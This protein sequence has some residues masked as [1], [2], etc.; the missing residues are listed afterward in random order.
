MPVDLS[1]A[2]LSDKSAEKLHY[3]G[4]DPG[5]H[6]AFTVDT[7]VLIDTRYFGVEMI[8]WLQSPCYWAKGAGNF[9]GETTEEDW[10][11]VASPPQSPKQ[12]AR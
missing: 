12:A 5:D 6:L 9:N 10:K 8:T 2:I 7:D 3:F 11:V 4:R 1:S